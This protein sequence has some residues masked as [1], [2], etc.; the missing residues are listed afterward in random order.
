MTEHKMENR[1]ID[2]Y[3]RNFAKQDIKY[4][5]MAMMLDMEL[6]KRRLKEYEIQNV[7][8]YGT[9]PLGVQL[10]RAISNIVNVLVFR[11]KR[12]ILTI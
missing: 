3:S 10:Y 11:D 4:T 7:S 1:M 8:I 9:G 2:I 6:I 5:M 12:I